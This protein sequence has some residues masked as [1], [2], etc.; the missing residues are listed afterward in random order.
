M[1][2]IDTIIIYLLGIL[3]IRQLIAQNLNIPLPK[4]L[5]W[6]L[7]DKKNL[8]QPVLC[9]RAYEINCLKNNKQSNSTIVKN[10]LELASRHIKYYEGGL[11][12]GRS[13][14]VQSQY[15]INTLE[16]SYNEDDLDIM[17]SALRTL[18][19]HSELPFPQ[20]DFVLYIKS[21]NQI[22]ARNIYNGVGDYM[23]YICRIDGNAGSYPLHT[24]VDM[25]LYSV[26]FENLDALLETAKHTSGKKLTGIA[27]DCSISTGNGLK[28]AIT[29]FNKLVKKGQYNI[30]EINHAFVLYAHK[31]YDD[32]KSQEFKLHRYFDM[33]EKT[34]ELI[35]KVSTGECNTGCEEVY[36]Y[37][38]GHNLLRYDL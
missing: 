26:Q 20:I 13:V 24:K 9:R 14:R 35:Y 37:L 32:G 33:D 22:L 3:T 8:E 23:I 17:T 7:Y 34:R 10:L 11:G 21:G 5:M 36:N 4:R 19:D 18:I 2:I 25:H 38:K 28:D 30:N 27:I 12:H 31:P 29:Q 16:A 1:N 6:L 15:F